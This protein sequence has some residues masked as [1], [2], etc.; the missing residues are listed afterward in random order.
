MK[1]IATALAATALAVLVLLT[2]GALPAITA[3]AASAS[4][5]S[6]IGFYVKAVLPEN[7]IDDSL[8]YFDL[9]VA[10]GQ[11]Q[12]LQVE[13]VNETDESITVDIGAISASTNRNGVIDYKTPNIRDKTLQHPFSEMAVLENTCLSI[14]AHK[15]Q[16]ARVTITLPQSEYDG[17]VLG[18]LVFTRRPEDAPAPSEG[19]ALQNVYSYVIGVK[20]SEN[21]TAVL[22]NFELESIEADTVNYQPAMVHLIRNK[23]AA[24]AKNMA[25]HVV[26]RDESG[27]TVAKVE[28]TGV[29]MAPNSAMALAV[30]PGEGAPSE[31]T[32]QTPGQLQPG[33]YT[34][35]I[36]LEM[37]G[38]SWNFQQAFTIGSIEAE[39]INSE[40]VGATTPATGLPLRTV[41]VILL[42][43][44][45][46]VILIL[47]IILLR[48]L[49][50]REETRELNRQMRK[51]RE[52]I[53]LQD[54]YNNKQ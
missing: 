8:T 33:H 19:M 1:K 11:T 18:A 10:P 4:T 16:T 25:L 6:G 23:N 13:V 49:R 42:A 38:Q 46:L 44:A 7:Q 17:V 5:G 41:L 53:R 15:S 36:T 21:D 43:V 39:S 12:T 31:S 48:V 20:L 28:R 30:T 27:N 24:I 14:P 34:S 52:R 26:V 50:R 51:R 54:R 40:S 9:R 29:D 35:E 37:D 32:A 45:S 22:P 3:H 2:A 47:V